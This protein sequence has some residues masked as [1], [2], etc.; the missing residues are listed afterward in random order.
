[1]HVDEELLASDEFT[2]GYASWSGTSFAAPFA[3]A[4]IARWMLANGGTFPQAVAEL[5]QHDHALQ[6]PGY[7]TIL[8]FALTRM[9][10]S[11]SSEWI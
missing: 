3:A 2:T 6:F 4:M 9:Q 7:G 10:V 11:R 1:M 8:S 5:V